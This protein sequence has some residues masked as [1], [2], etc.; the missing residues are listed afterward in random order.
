[1]ISWWNNIFKKETPIYEDWYNDY[2]SIFTKKNNVGDI[3][4]QDFVV[5]DTETTGLDTIKDAILTIGAVR[6]KNNVVDISS[7]IAIQVMTEIREEK[8]AHAIGIHGL[9]KTDKRGISSQE[10]AQ[11]F[12]KY[13][14]DGIIVGHHI[15]FDWIMLEKLSKE[16]GG[17]PI[18]NKKID[19]STLAK[20]LDDPYGQSHIN[21]MDYTLDNLC[22]KY[23]II[24]KA[25]HTADGDAYIT[26]ILL[27]KLLNR[28]LK[29]GVCQIQ[30]VLG[31]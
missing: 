9:I 10:A 14:E 31:R 30:G 4:Q 7:A 16:N 25:R 20:R 21:P 8:D 1:M 22:Q 17:G 18:L 3:L 28:L 23:N 5:L 12:F 29:K 27:L 26:A 24:T 11:Q 19:T 13:L 2:Q 6:V 15:A